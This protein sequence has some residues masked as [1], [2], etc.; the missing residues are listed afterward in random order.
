[1]TRKLFFSVLLVLV[2]SIGFL[3]CQ[4]AIAAQSDIIDSGSCGK[5]LTWTLDAS[6]ILTISGTGAMKNYEERPDVPWSSY[7]SDI[8]AVVIGNG[9]TSIGDRSFSWC[10]RLTSVTIPDSVTTIGQYAFTQCGITNITIGSG[11]TSIG[12][13]AFSKAPIY[14]IINHSVVRFPHLYQKHRHSSRKSVLF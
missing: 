14:K 4:T 7:D 10:K 3:F 13:D 2:L 9:V 8:T 12:A 6:G 11:V 1:M 5:N